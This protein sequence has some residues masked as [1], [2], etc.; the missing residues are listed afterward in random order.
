MTIHHRL[1]G[2]SKAMEKK[3]AGQTPRKGFM[4]PEE[5]DG[6]LNRGFGLRDPTVSHN[7]HTFPKMYL[8]HGVFKRG[9]DI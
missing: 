1:K 6:T 9:G 5:A 2:K 4:G 3:K 8:P 7:R